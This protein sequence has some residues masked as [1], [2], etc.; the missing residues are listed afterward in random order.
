MT[1]KSSLKCACVCVFDYS[2]CKRSGWRERWAVVQMVIRLLGVL[3]LLS[4]A[5]CNCML[6]A[7]SV[8][9]LMN[10][11]ERRCGRE[12][13]C[14]FSG[15]HTHSTHPPLFCTHTYTESQSRHFKRAHSKLLG[16]LEKKK[17]LQFFRANNNIYI[18]CLYRDFEL[19][20][21]FFRD[22]K[23]DALSWVPQIRLKM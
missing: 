13:E 22:L 6:C 5:G 1:I 23:V 17:V 8:P 12:Y 4:Y 2:Q 16:T 3:I 18:F 9:S 20:I 19:A 7:A 14:L 21:W 15:S 11:R 10:G